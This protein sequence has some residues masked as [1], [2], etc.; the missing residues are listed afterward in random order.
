MGLVF[1]GSVHGLSLDVDVGDFRRTSWGVKEGAPSAILAIAQTRDGYLWLANAEGLFRFDGLRFQRHDLPRNSRVPS[2]AVYSLF[3]PASGG[4]WIGFT[5]GGAAFLKGGQLIIYT[6]QDGMPPGSVYSFAQDRDGIL[7]AGTTTGLARLDG[8]RWT[9]VGPREGY[10]SAMTTALLLDSAGTLWAIGQRTVY[11]LPAGAKVF[12]TLM[13]L[14]QDEREAGIAESPSGE[15]WLST[16]Q[17]LLKLRQNSNPQQ[18]VAATGFLIRFDREGGL[19]SRWEG[20]IRRFARPMGMKDMRWAQ[21]KARINSYSEYGVTRASWISGFYEDREGNMWLAS[22]TSLIRLSEPRTTRL[23]LFDRMGFSSYE[24]GLAPADQGSVWISSRY[25]APL[26]VRHGVATR[27]ARLGSITC[28]MRADDGTIWFGGRKGLWKHTAQRLEHV[29]LPQGVE[30]EVQAI[31]QTRDGALWVS[32]VR[33]GVFRL[34]GGLWTA[35]GGIDALPRLTAVTLSTDAAGRLWFG[36]TEG[37]VAMLEG[38]R[39]TV[40][41]DQRRLGVG[42]VTALYGKRSRVWAGGEFGLALLDGDAFRIVTPSTGPVLNSVSGIIET[43]DGTLWVN[44]RDGVFHFSAAE[45]RLMA[46]QADYRPSAEVFNAADGIEGSAATLRPLPTAVEGS[47]GRLWFLTNAGVYAIDPARIHRNPV[48]P[49]VLIESLSAGD[50]S[51]EPGPSVTLAQGT[52]ALRIGYVG[53]SLSMPEKVRYRYRIEDLDADWRDVGGQREALYTDLGPG[54]YRFQV[55]AANG[56]GVW[57]ETGATMDIVIPPTF[58]QTGWFIVL[59][60]AGAGLLVWAVVRLRVRQISVRMRNR[61]EARMAERERIAR[62]LH[63]TLLQSTQG[64]ILQFQAAVNRMAVGD[65]ARVALDEALN[66]GEA[67]LT[68]GRD[69]VL[70]LRVSAEPMGEL[71]EAFAATGAELGHGRE[72]CFRAVVDGTPRSLRPVVREEVYRIGREALLNAFR[73]SKASTIEV[74]LIYADEQLRVRVRD[75]GIGVDA[76]TLDAAARQDHWGVRGMRERAERI[77]AELVFLSRSGAGTEM[78]L[79]I[80][81]SMAYLAPS[82]R[83]RWLHQRSHE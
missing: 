33:N 71:P 11:F 50:T 45:T 24:A 80:A 39:V 20:G 26:H 31:A 13:P 48:P 78:T 27:P 66:R 72:V 43:A 40:F 14:S 19:W 44:S 7:W 46:R 53:L 57:N 58:V 52:T 65:P 9:K 41:S 59:C 42:H 83:R 32:I 67:V 2:R 49:P 10:S 54:S 63:D 75:D 37:R 68:E 17:R 8:A 16:A 51:V 62:E 28:T 15:V 73:H 76:S 4:L 81:A 79:S 69:R 38:D 55:V 5:F 1:S 70:D 77:G 12:Q 64:L 60:A 3:A 30:D 29:A 61:Y 35:Y 74:H 21:V 23:S 36:Y 22:A 25:L 82:R 56:D 6:E 47:D 34:A 18:Q